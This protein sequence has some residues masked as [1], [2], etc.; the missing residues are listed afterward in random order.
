MS[1]QTKNPLAEI[2]AGI[3]QLKFAPD[4]NSNEN[5]GFVE[6]I[7]SQENFCGLIEEIVGNDESLA[8]VSSRSYRHVNHFDKIVLFDDGNPDHARLTL[9]LWRPPYTVGEIQDELIHDHRFSF[10]SKVLCGAL[11]SEVFERT[12]ED[13]PN[14]RL[15]RAYSYCPE[16]KDIANFYKHLGDVRLK[17]CKYQMTDQDR[18]YYLSFDTIHRICLPEQ[19]TVSTLVLRSPRLRSHS[20]VYNS[21]YPK[22]E[23]RV[24]N[25]FFSPDNLSERLRFLRSHILEH[26]SCTYPETT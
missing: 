6:R 11:R 4:T 15:Y 5:A 3:V 14:A 21:V 16:N 13:C 20:T 8:V 22:T 10:W 23:L 26:A 12:V 1:F 2:E 24:Q 25:S 9:H 17:I 18:T 19:H 7:G